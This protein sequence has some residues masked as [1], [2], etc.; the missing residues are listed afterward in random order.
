MI[1]GEGRVGDGDHQGVREEAHEGIHLDEGNV[2]F[3]VAS[4]WGVNLADHVEVFAHFGVIVATD[5]LHEIAIEVVLAELDL[6]MVWTNVC[7]GLRGVAFESMLF[8]NKMACCGV[9][10]Q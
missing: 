10:T 2:D 6:R 3:I 8:G 9:E 7:E 4:F 1:G 5:Q